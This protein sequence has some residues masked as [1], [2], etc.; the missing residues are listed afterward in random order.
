MKLTMRHY[1][2]EDDYW[3]IRDFLHEIYRLNGRRELSWQAY[4]FDYCR[5]H[6]FENIEHLRMEEVVFI[7]ETPDGRIAAVLNPETSGDT[8][9]QAHPSLRTAALEDE[10][11][12]VA[13]ERLACPGKNDR[14]QLRVGPTSAIICVKTS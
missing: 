2:D 6:C 4:R 10:M 5:W 3:R 12:H 11:L 9:L 8:F 13:E 14:R 1:R 7:W